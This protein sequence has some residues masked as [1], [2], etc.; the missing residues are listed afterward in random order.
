[1]HCSD[2]GLCEHAE[3]VLVPG[4]GS[5]EPSLMFVGIAPGW[6]EDR[7]GECFVGKSG[8]KVE[9]MLKNVNIPLGDVRFENLVRCVPWKNPHDK[10]KVRDPSAEEIEACH[11][12]LLSAISKYEPDIIVPLGKP[13]TFFFLPALGKDLKITKQRG[14]AFNWTHPDTEKEYTVIPTLHPAAVLRNQNWQDKVEEDIKYAYEVSQGGFRNVFEDCD[15]LYLDTEEKITD[16]VDMVIAQYEEDPDNWMNVVSV[17]VETMFMDPLPED[18]PIEAGKVLL[19]PYGP[20]SAVASIQLSHAPKKGALIPVWHRDSPL[21]DYTSLCMISAQLQRLV[22]VVPVIGQNFKFD[23]QVLYVLMSVEVKHFAFDSMLAHYLM[24]QKTQSLALE[25]LA[26]KYCEMPKFKQEMDKSLHSLPEK[27]RHHGNVPLDK[28]IDYGC[29]DV[30]AVFRYYVHWYPIMEEQ[31]FLDVY[32]DVLQDATAS[33]ARMEINGMYIDKDCLERLKKEYPEELSALRNEICKNS[34]VQNLE[35]TR[36]E[37]H[38]G[39]KKAERA[40]ENAKRAK[41]G[42]PPVRE[43]NWSQEVLDKR[44]KK[45]LEKLAFNPNSSDQL[46]RLFYDPDFMGFDTEGKGKTKTKQPSADKEARKKI[47]EDAHGELSALIEREDDLSE[48]DVDEV[49]DLKECIST[50][51][52]ISTWVGQNK[53]YSAYVKGAEELIYDKGDIEFSWPLEFP[54]ECCCWCFHANF[55]IHGTD[56]GRLCVSGDTMLETSLGNCRISEL[57]LTK[58]QDVTIL[59]HRL[60]RKKILNKFFKGNEEMFRVTLANGSTIK[61]TAGHRFLT[62]S[63]WKRLDEIKEGD[64]IYSCK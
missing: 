57:V 40:A 51:E 22:D 37:E 49:I 44:E 35:A 20:Y 33:L 34:H 56:T 17:D 52:K 50:I 2:C 41:E 18:Y 47:L 7:D 9:E 16:Y 45:L 54:S 24:Y 6:Q 43:V 30:D 28:L 13:P 64:G 46:R 32:E 27:R 39:K 11:H 3:S 38:Y 61:C 21:K 36:L 31:G 23:Y 14:I 5:E 25:D 10:G 4:K 8:K 48:E 62:E 55:K 26:G 58:T 63:G 1:M 59:T 12:Y 42:R 29:G 19:R 15:Y 53:L 60:R